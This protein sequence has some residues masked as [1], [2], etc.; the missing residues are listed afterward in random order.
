MILCASTAVVAV[1]CGTV[2]PERKSSAPSCCILTL[3]PQNAKTSEMED[4]SK[5]ARG[6]S[7][8][9][10]SDTR[11]TTPVLMK[12]ALLDNLATTGWASCDCRMPTH[13]SASA[14]KSSEGSMFAPS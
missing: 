14:A 7:L 2:V 13:A 8:K 11:F 1:C 4:E 6:S 12:E 10:Q 9:N 5:P 3:A